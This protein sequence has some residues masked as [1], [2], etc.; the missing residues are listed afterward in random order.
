MNPVS[1][2]IISIAV[3]AAIFSVAYY[4]SFLPLRKAQMF[5]ATLQGLQSTPATSLLDLETR[6]SVPLNAPSPI[7]QEELVRNTANS[8]LNFV[9]QSPNTSSTVELVNFLMSYYGP[10]LDRGRGMSF[11]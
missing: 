8:V 3:S 9:Q 2:K 11:G 4:G 5:I 10:I 1:K 6:L 7:G